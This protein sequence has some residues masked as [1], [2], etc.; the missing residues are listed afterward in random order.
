MNT[1]RVAAPT[2]LVSVILAV[3]N[4]LDSVEEAVNSIRNQ[5]YTAW[6]LVIVDDG[7]TDGTADKLAALEREDPRIRLLRNPVNR[8]L[9][10]SLNLGWTQAR[11]TLIAR[12]DADDVSL[13]GRLARQ[14]A[15]MND[16][17]E[18]AVLGGGAELVDRAGRCL[19]IALRPE[20]H[21]ELAARI[22]REVPHIHPTV[23]MRRHFLEEMGGYDARVVRAEDSDLWLRAYRRFR[24]HNLREPLIRYRLPG[25]PTW[26]TIWGGTS[27][28]LHTAVRQGPLL[29]FVW[30]AGRFATACL[31]HKAGLRE[32]RLR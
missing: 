1:S 31:L 24:L 18:V 25:R 2:P 29:R 30:A 9:G 7:S 26:S 32:T 13:P 5:T 17:P 14:V 23:M 15:F 12:M 3:Y 16:H 6:E 11:G 19:G 21:E 27:M 20:C 4:Q 22:F 28:L 10:A 8:G